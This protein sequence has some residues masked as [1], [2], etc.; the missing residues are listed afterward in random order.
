MPSW[1]FI[2]QEKRLQI[3]MSLHLRHIL[4][5]FQ[6]NQFLLLLLNVLYLAE[7]E[8]ANTN[9]SLLWQRLRLKLTIYSTFNMHINY[10]TNNEVSPDLNAISIKYG[11]CHLVHYSVSVI[12]QIHRKSTCFDFCCSMNSILLSITGKDNQLN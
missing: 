5:R 8:A 4:S 11:C 10:Y 9:F 12:P 7:R 2:V 3:D 6:A 1:I